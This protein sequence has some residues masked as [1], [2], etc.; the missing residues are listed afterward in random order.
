MAYIET[1]DTQNYGLTDKVTEILKKYKEAQSVKDYWKDKFEEAYEYCLP[2]RESFY[3]ESPGQK[4]TDKIFD[5]TAV[6]GVQEFASRLQAGITPTFARWAD[7]QAGS[8]IPPEQKPGINQE[9]DKIT[10]YVFQVLQTSNFN[11]EI[12]EAF[13]D[14]A[15]GTGILLVEEGDAINPIK[16]TSVPLTRVCLMN[17]PDGKID[18]VYRTRTCKPN[19]INLLYPKAK[20]PENFDPLKQKKDIKL[21]EA[22]YKIYEDNVEKYKFCVV[23]ENPKHI[24]LEEEYSGDGSNPYLVFR[25]NKASGEV[26]GRGPVFNAM[27]AIKTCNLTIELILQNAQMSV[28]G[29]YTYE[30]DGVINPDNISLVPG[31]LIPVAPGSKGL[32]P[33]QAASNF[34]VAQLVLNDMRQNIKKA[35]YMEALGRPEGTPMTATE[36]S[37]RMA[38]L[39]R[40]IGASF[41][42][43]QSELINPL[44]R[45]IIRILSKQGRIEI[46]KVNGREVKIAPRSPLAQAQHL[47]DVA[48]VTR[49]NEIIAGTF[50]PQMINLIVDQN[51]TAKYLA[52]KMNLPEKL[53]RDENEQKQLADRMTQLQQSA[54]EGGEVP[55]GT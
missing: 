6:V 13:M 42:R 40:Q 44:L 32:L 53:I 11:Q 29:V 19:E 1:E 12:H 38:D 49:F 52:E 41:G 15:I 46:P 17:G 16:F 26:Y 22:I 21:I 55:P 34:D 35:L 39:S 25:W 50:G 4:R 54:Q 43:L 30:D 51:E 24:L 33:I 8:E 31:S 14:L 20:L 47:Q 36:V 45:R 3:D 48:D 27:G 10:D 18:T 23:M 9:L 5:E 2:N 28:S 7:F 37:E